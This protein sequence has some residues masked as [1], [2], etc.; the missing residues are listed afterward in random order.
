MS[1]AI[2]H[3]FFQSLKQSGLVKV[4]LGALM[5]LLLLAMPSSLLFAQSDSPALVISDG[6]AAPGDEVTVPVTFTANGNNITSMIFSVD[7]DESRLSF[8]DS[9]G[10][11]DGMPDA[12]SLSIPGAFNGSVTFDGSDNDG[13]IDLFIADTFPPLATLP[14]GVMATITFTV[15]ADASGDAAINFSSEPAASFGN[16]GGQ[17]VAGTTD[18]GLLSISGSSGGNPALDIQDQV[19]ASSNSQ[20]TVPVTFAANGSNISSL[21][22]SVDYDQSLLTFDA[23]DSDADGIPDAVSLNVPAAFGGAGVTFDGSDDD[24]ELDFFIADIAPPLASLP[25]GTIAEITFEVGDPDST[26]EA[27]VNFSSDPAASF[28]DT[29]GNDATGT[30]DNG[31]VLISVS[32]GSTALACDDVVVYPNGAI[33][34]S[35]MAQ[36]TNVYGLQATVDVDDPAL[37]DLLDSSFGDFFEQPI[38]MA[39]NKIDPDDD[40]WLGGA[41]QQNP[42][43]PISGQGRFATLLYKAN[44]ST[45][46]VTLTITSLF[47]DRDGATIPSQVSTCILTIEPFGGID[48]IVTYQ[49]RTNHANIEVVAAGPSAKNDTTDSSGAFML[50]Q[51]PDGTTY[52]VTADA[53][54]YL[55]ACT[56]ATVEVV[57]GQI[58][59]LTTTKLRGGDLNADLM[60]NIGD[61]TRLSASFNNP[62]SAD[63]LADIN[64]NGTIDIGDWS[65]LQGNYDL[66]GCQ[67][68]PS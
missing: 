19:A 15:L 45:G 44:G 28:G 66:V 13:E 59:T 10:D 16:T 12:V 61:A 8:D 9:D 50:D 1:T 26:T 27:A 54:S 53:P 46:P 63:T 5:A 42:N 40:S 49:G 7:Y 57:S 30:T 4:G 38:A 17:S 2:N 51:L 3:V 25:N 21:V 58:T 18:D 29:D 14:D 43:G 55:R 47:S 52:Q 6:S 39:S 64:A 23:T 65:I 32:D 24:G 41:S 34:V 35:L 20:V 60:I 33:A 56:T 36:G 48:G 22:F 31:S 62:A 67:N 68:W 11:G 37:V